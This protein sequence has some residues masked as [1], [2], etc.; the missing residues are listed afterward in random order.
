MGAAE[1][2]VQY[3]AQKECLPIV[4]T[5]N[6]GP[7]L[8]GRNWLHKIVLD[9]KSLLCPEAHVIHFKSQDSVAELLTQFSDVFK[10]ELGTFKNTLIHIPV[11]AEE[12]T[13][14]FKANPV[15]YALKGKIETELERLVSLGMCK[16]VAY[17]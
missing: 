16:H 1:V 11:P 5:P 10:P 8:L 14:F 4:I 3:T 9:W 6:R 13:K 15:P 17:S 7:T 2:T 12:T